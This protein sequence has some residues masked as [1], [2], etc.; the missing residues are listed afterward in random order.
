MGTVR[1]ASRPS[2]FLCCP[3][4]WAGGASWGR[5]VYGRYPHS[6]GVSARPCPTQ[7]RCP[8]AQCQLALAGPH[9]R[10]CRTGRHPRGRRQQLPRP[11]LCFSSAPPHAGT[12]RQCLAAKNEFRGILEVW[13]LTKKNTTI[14]MEGSESSVPSLAALIRATG[15]HSHHMPRVM[16]FF[17][18]VFVRGASWPWRGLRAVALR[19]GRPR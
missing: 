6:T 9:P 17:S 14:P 15:T 5:P 7:R 10:R 12:H 8:T 18:S 1:G 2:P 3:R 19:V 16:G 4:P 11:P 13:L